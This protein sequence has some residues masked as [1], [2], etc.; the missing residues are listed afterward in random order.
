MYEVSAEARFPAGDFVRKPVIMGLAPSLAPGVSAGIR[1]RVVNSLDVPLKVM[2]FEWD[3]LATT[4]HCGLSTAT[5]QHHVERVIPVGSK[6]DYTIPDAITQS[7]IDIYPTGVQVRLTMWAD[8][9]EPPEE[10]SVR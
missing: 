8:R 7:V 1:V 9:H 3:A 10:V 4:H 5:G 6:W 2:G